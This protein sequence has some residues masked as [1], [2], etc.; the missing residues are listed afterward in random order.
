[1]ATPASA[2]PSVGSGLRRCAGPLRPRLG[3]RTIPA[4]LI[5]ASQSS[6]LGAVSDGDSGLRLPFGRL[7]PAS[8][9]RAAR[10][11]AR[12]AHDTCAPDPRLSVV[13]DRERLLRTPPHRLLD[14]RAER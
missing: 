10:A 6:A 9:R 8:L 2:S 12:A 7:R 11:P 1:M 3:R 5:L 4:P 13:L 14:L